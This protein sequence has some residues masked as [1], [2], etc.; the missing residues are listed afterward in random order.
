MRRL[1]RRR[2]AVK[3]CVICGFY[4]MDGGFSWGWRRR[5]RRRQRRRRRGCFVVSTSRPDIFNTPISVVSGRRRPAALSGH[6]VSR[7]T[8][9][10]STREPPRCVSL[11]TRG[12]ENYTD[13]LKTAH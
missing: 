5:R 6:H 2:T 11:G 13:V 10:K 1:V 8:P 3:R 4:E 12:A 9:V 7:E